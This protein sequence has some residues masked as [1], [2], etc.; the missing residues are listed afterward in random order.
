MVLIPVLDNV[1]GRSAWRRLE[2]ELAQDA[3]RREGELVVLLDRRLEVVNRDI[4][5]AL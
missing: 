2:D 3:G 5:A 1:I 4:H